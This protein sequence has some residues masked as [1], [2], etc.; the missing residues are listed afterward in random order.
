MLIKITHKIQRLND[1]EPISNFFLKLDKSKNRDV[2]ILNPQISNDDVLNSMKNSL[3]NN[4]LLN[5]SLIKLYNNVENNAMLASKIFWLSIPFLVTSS[6]K[7]N[8]VK[9]FAAIVQ[10]CAILEFPN[11]CNLRK[12][13]MQ[14]EKTLALDF[15]KNFAKSISMLISPILLNEESKQFA[16]SILKKY[17]VKFYSHL[18]NLAY[19]LLPIYA[20]G[21]Q[22]D[23]DELNINFSTLQ[24]YTTMNF[25]PSKAEMQIWCALFIFWALSVDYKPQRSNDLLD[26]LD[27]MMSTLNG[28]TALIKVKL[29]EFV[30]VQ[31][32]NS[33]T[34]R[35]RIDK[36]RNKININHDFQSGSCELSSPIVESK[37]I[38]DLN[39]ITLQFIIG[40][41]E[42][43]NSP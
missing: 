10:H 3:R 1:E 6:T 39:D 4:D 15:S 17:Y 19:L 31:S 18:E 43:L 37:N 40:T 8:S 23:L 11:N 5:F 21:Q 32:L 25:N 30:K 38:T 20:F 33:F 2:Y 41:Q 27:C 22:T 29:F 42:Y 7:L 13:I 26:A 14:F 34:S 24:Y 12:A 35:D 16:L 36:L 28:F 9:L